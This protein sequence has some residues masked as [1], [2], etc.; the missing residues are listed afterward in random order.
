MIV[1]E[2]KDSNNGFGFLKFWFYSISLQ[3]S[4]LSIFMPGIRTVVPTKHYKIKFLI[5]KRLSQ[6]KMLSSGELFYLA[7]FIEGKS[8]PLIRDSTGE[9]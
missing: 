8:V 6:K 7:A 1:W 3:Y 4:A 9:M 2:E 5:K